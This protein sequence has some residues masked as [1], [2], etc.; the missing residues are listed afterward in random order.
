MMDPDYVSGK[1]LSGYELITFPDPFITYGTVNVSSNKGI[2]STW[3]ITGCSK[4]TG[5]LFTQQTG[6]KMI[7]LRTGTCTVTWNSITGFISPAPV[8]FVL[9]RGEIKDIYGE[10]SPTF[11]PVCTA[12]WSTCSTTQT[13]SSLGDVGGTISLG[14][15]SRTCNGSLEVDPSCTLGASMICPPIIIEPP[16]TGAC[17]ANPACDGNE[18][19][20]SCPSQ[21]KPKWLHF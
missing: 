2:L 16:H 3:N 12:T 1:S 8:S 9:G 13:C 14:T 15:R 4:T 21:C 7:Y 18:T 19:I 11:P 6:D 10:Y 20:F 5:A 17:N